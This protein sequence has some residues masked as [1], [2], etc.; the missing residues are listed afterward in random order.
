[1]NKKLND[2]EKLNDNIEFEVGG[3]GQSISDFENFSRDS[4]K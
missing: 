2:K 3:A 4:L 1:M